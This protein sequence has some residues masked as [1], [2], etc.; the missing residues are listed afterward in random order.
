ML[1]LSKDIW[2]YGPYIEHC[3]TNTH[4][5]FHPLSSTFSAIIVV[6]YIFL[7]SFCFSTFPKFRIL[8][9]ET[10]LGIFRVQ[11]ESQIDLMVLNVDLCLQ[12]FCM[13]S[14]LE[15]CN[16]S[17]YTKVNSIQSVVHACTKLSLN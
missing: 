14:W 8:I 17:G 10:P 7:V 13:A 5:I 1:A 12:F 4:Q 3:P 9:R 16:L 6:E 11:K 2:T 15:M